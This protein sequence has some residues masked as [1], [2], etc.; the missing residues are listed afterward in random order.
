MN[1]RTPAV[2]FVEGLLNLFTVNSAGRLR[3]LPGLAGRQRR[4][5]HGWAEPSRGRPFRSLAVEK[6]PL[7]FDLIGEPKE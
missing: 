2:A 3:A 1:G 4:T 5:S 6:N 7:R